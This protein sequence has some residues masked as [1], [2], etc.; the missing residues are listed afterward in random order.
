MSWLVGSAGRVGGLG[1]PS[2]R[3]WRAG[4]AGT[5]GLV[6]GHGGQGRGARR[7]GSGGHWRAGSGGHW[8]AG[9]AGM[10]GR[11]ELGVQGGAGLVVR[12]ERAG[13]VRIGLGRVVPAVNVPMNGSWRCVCLRSWHVG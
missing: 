1:W 5:A 2:R 6:G 3:A 13:W 10:A 8:R 11:V 9:S 7:A 4:S 12:E